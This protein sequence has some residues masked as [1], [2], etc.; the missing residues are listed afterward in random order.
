MVEDNF[1][2]TT[3]ALKALS[4]SHFWV[5]YGSTIFF[6]FGKL[7]E[8]IRKDGT[9][10]NPTGEITVG[11]EF[12]WRVENQSEILFGSDDDL[13]IW[14][15]KLTALIGETLIGVDLFGRLPELSLS[16]KSGIRVVSFTL[17]DGQP[18]WMILDRRVGKKRSFGVEN[19]VLM[20]E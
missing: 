5:G 6:E 10:G 16:F 9:V 17:F 7:T 11:I 19:G 3:R 20:Q 4:L 14:E 1:R 13:E 15:P 18:D 8:R 2:E 12:Y